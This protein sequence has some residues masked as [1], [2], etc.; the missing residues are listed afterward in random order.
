MASTWARVEVG[1][2]E[3]A[4]GCEIGCDAGWAAEREAV[5]W[6]ELGAV[7][8]R[9]RAVSVRCRR[10]PLWEVRLAW[11]NEVVDCLENALEHALHV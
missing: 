2:P 5:A 10:E 7:V 6:Y 8:V 9:F 4:A 1:F 3:G 11:S